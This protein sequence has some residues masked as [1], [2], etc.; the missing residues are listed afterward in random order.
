MLKPEAG[1]AREGA[2]EVRFVRDTGLDGSIVSARIS[3]DG[4]PVADVNT[5][6]V[7]SIWVEPG[8]HAFNMQPQPNIFGHGLVRQ[9]EGEVEAGRRIDVRISYGDQGLAFAPFA[10]SGLTAAN[11]PAATVAPATVQALP[12]PV[13][14]PQ[15]VPAAPAPAPAKAAASSTTN[16]GEWRDIASAPVGSDRFLL[17]SPGLPPY[18]G[19]RASDGWHEAS[20]STTADRP[21]DPQPRYWMPIPPPPGS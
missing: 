10:S 16:N 19:R 14:V 21:A 4:M 9:L 5:G 1:L 13:V 18:I 11:P 15:A 12:P 7:L 2:G 20:I 6:E 17:Y 8:H 3:V